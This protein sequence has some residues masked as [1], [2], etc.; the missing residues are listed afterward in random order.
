MAAATK[1]NAPEPSKTKITV[2]QRKARPHDKNR[3]K[4]VDAKRLA[5]IASGCFDTAEVRKWLKFLDVRTLRLNMTSAWVAVRHDL[6]TKIKI[7]R[8]KLAPTA[9]KVV[10][11][12][13]YKLGAKSAK[14][15][16]E[17]W[18]AIQEHQELERRNNI[19]I[20]VTTMKEAIATSNWEFLRQALVSREK[21]KAD[22]WAILTATEKQQLE[23]IVPVEIKLLKTAL[24]QGVIAAFNEDHEGGIFWIWQDINSPPDLVSGTTVR[25]IYRIP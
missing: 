7:A 3:L 6:A 9:A 8:N 2:P 17:N 25:N 24:K 10:D 16:A 14:D 4:W 1:S 20:I 18:A 11:L 23:A 21:Y 19:S 12:V 5:L 13:G 22:A 15:C